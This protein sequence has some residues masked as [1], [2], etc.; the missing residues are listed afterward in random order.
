MIN[1]VSNGIIHQIRQSTWLDNAAKG[2]LISKFRKPSIDMVYTKLVS[3]ATFI[4][5]IYDQVNV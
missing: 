5:H 1:G 4:A 3:N 2:I